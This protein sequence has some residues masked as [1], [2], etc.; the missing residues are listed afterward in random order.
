MTTKRL[1]ARELV[2]IAGACAALIAPAGL[3]ALSAPS[4]SP[5]AVLLAS[6]LQGTLGSALGPG[7]SLYVVEGA[8]GRIRRIDPQTGDVTT[9]ASGLP[10]AVVG[11]GGVVDVAFYGQTAYALTTLVGPD[12]G[13]NDVAG[14]YQI[15]G[16]TTATPIADLGQFSI[17]NPPKTPFDVR[18]GLQYAL[19]PFRGGFLVTDGHLNRVLRVGR[20]G[21]ISELIA[22]D[23]IVPTGL[24]VSGETVY[25]A[26]A[27]PVPHLAQDGKIVAF[28]AKPAGVSVI[29]TGASLLVD[30]EFGRGR[31]LY[32]LSQGVFPPDG[33][34]A[35]PAIPNTGALLR[36]NANGTFTVVAGGLNQPTSF[37][38]IGTTAYF[39]TLGGEVW[40]IEDV[41]DPPFGHR[42]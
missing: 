33:D 36:V 39:V 14:I 26:Q 40:K 8:V 11:L 5:T 23:N 20:R 30:V 2:L 17:A 42:N 1:L 41:A 31:T 27:G 24:A 38:F 16:P 3:S 19:E 7:G 9:F 15:T 10:P 12:F 4:E 21:E 37:E 25:M 6:G 32:A 13:T 29:A 18:A 22:F 28:G 34:P 35:E